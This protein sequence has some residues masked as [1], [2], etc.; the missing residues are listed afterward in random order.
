MVGDRPS[1]ILA[2][3]RVGCKTILI[4]S[5]HHVTT[6]IVCDVDLSNIIPDIR[7]QNLKYGVAWIRQQEAKRNTS[8][9]QDLQRMDAA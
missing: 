2:G 4:E 1:D 5:G 3:K 7:V 6:P 8:T 9:D